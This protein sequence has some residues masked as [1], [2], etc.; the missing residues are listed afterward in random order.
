MLDLLKFL[1]D[2]MKGTYVMGDLVFSIFSNERFLDL[3][4][5]QYGYE[6]CTPLHSYGPYVRNH[7]LFHYVISGHGTLIVNGV[8]GHTQ[9]FHLSPNTGFLILPGMVNTYFA[10]QEDPWEYTWIEF[11][12][13]KT[14]EFLELAGLNGNSPLYTPK[15]ITGGHDVRDE[16]LYIVRHSQASALNLIGHLYLFLD[17]V[18]QTSTTQ[19]KGQG[20]KLRDF[21]IKE[22]LVFIEQNYDKVI[23]V[24]DMARNC[25]LNRSYFGKIFREVIGNSPQEFLI[26]Y[27][28]EKATEKLKLTTSPIG[29]IS[30]DVGYPNPLHFSR[31]FKKIYGISPREY[32]QANQNLKV[33]P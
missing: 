31:A 29:K 32:R 25:S 13:I 20:Y 2:Y 17:H 12:G 7:Y 18:V 4:L 8:S 16:M 14:K 33:V 15:T 22:T 6:K 9:E 24:E 30:V 27:R 3:S 5:Y 23:T 1:L 11:D 21:Y 28:M 19:K 26:Q 10:D